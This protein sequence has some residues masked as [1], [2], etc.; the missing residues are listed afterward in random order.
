MQIK[1]AAK[2]LNLTPRI[3]RH[4]EQAGLLAPARDANGYRSYGPAD[5]RKAGRI[6]DMI[7]TGFSTREVLAMAPCLTDEGAGAC[8]AGLADLKHK[9]W[10]IDRLIGDLQTR[11][12]A[13]LDR[14]ASFES[15]LS[16]RNERE[17]PGHETPNHPAVSDRFS[18]RK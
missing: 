2:E 6:R 16:H 11:R 14:I 5:L 10:Q 4:Y 15:T 8:E 3:L 9:L 12:A 7:A 18:G 1:D 17:D 13:T